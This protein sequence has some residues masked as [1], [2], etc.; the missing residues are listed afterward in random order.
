MT[1][2][3]CTLWCDSDYGEQDVGEVVF[4][5]ATCVAGRFVNQMW[6]EMASL[7]NVE[8]VPLPATGWVY[9]CVSDRL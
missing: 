1:G 9:L 2:T 3:R 8:S 7:F 4:G 5:G 6:P